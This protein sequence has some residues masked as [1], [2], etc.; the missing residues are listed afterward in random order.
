MTWNVRGDIYV[1]TGT[2]RFFHWRIQLISIGARAEKKTER[3]RALIEPALFTRPNVQLQMVLMNLPW[4][5]KIKGWLW[6]VVNKLLSGAYHLYWYKPTSSNC[7]LNRGYVSTSY[8]DYP[9]WWLVFFSLMSMIQYEAVLT[10]VIDR[11]LNIPM[12]NLRCER[13]VAAHDGSKLSQ[14][15]GEWCLSVMIESQ[16][17]GLINKWVTCEHTVVEPNSGGPWAC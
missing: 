7:T 16:L 5:M 14:W 12:G 2:R 6:W 8:S 1:L 13:T 11:S 4:S 3:K 15:V 10:D 9:N 17:L